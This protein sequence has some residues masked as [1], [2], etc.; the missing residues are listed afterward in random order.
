MLL[1]C[2]TT[3]F[4][5]V[6]RK[7]YQE[8]PDWAQFRGLK[9]KVQAL[10]TYLSI[11]LGY[12]VIILFPHLSL[13]WKHFL[14]NLQSVLFKEPMKNYCMQRLLNPNLAYLIASLESVYQK[15][16]RAG[17]L[18]SSRESQNMIGH[19]PVESDLYWPCVEQRWWKVCLDLHGP[20]PT[21]MT[22]WSYKVSFQ[23]RRK[24]KNIF[25][26]ASFSMLS[27]W[28]TLRRPS[29][30]FTTFTNFRVFL[31]FCYQAAIC[32]SGLQSFSEE[33]VAIFWRLM[34]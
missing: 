19:D 14:S 23:G 26:T 25:K 3:Y 16:T 29:Y 34:G 33:P 18:W 27:F 11:I 12:S 2:W 7:S 20:L 22:L 9:F 1:K 10:N 4:M 24:R 8:H 30:T 5:F 17:A 15:N 28:K 13:Y 31:V 6:L 21:Q 32:S